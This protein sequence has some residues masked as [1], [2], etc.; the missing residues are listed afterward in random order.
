MPK[1]SVIVP[2]YNT[3]K[4]LPRCIDSILAQTFTDFELILVNDGSTDNSG[5]ICDGYAKKDSRIVVIHKDNGGV[6]SAR[7]R[8][9][10]MAH[11]EWITFVDSDDELYDRDSLNQLQLLINDDIEFVIAGYVYCNEFGIVT[12]KINESVEQTINPIDGIFLYYRP[13]YFRYLGHICSKLYNNALIKT[14]KLK[15]N[16]DISYNEDGLFH[17]Q[18]CLLMTGKIKFSTIPLYRYYLL[19]NSA[20]GKLGQ[21]FEKKFFTDF[22][23]FTIML[24]LITPLGNDRLVK[25]AKNAIINSYN[26]IILMMYQHND[27]DKKT[28]KQLKQQMLSKIGKWFY[29]KYK[30]WILKCNLNTSIYKFIHK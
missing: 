5:K 28:H 8:G 10:D 18:Y 17:V 1:V 29:I 26:R 9:I 7:N 6:S 14:N 4:Y 15:F 22:N 16:E 2:V 12:Y 24:D 3:E 21:K 25:L 19:P 27:H 11:G 23:A 30:I 20:M 13:K